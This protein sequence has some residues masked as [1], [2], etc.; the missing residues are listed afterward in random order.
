VDDVDTIA[1]E[2]RA[3]VQ[4]APWAREIEVADPDGNRLRIGTATTERDADG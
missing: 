2:L 1:S 4:T 3:T